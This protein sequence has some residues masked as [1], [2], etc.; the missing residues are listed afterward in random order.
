MSR[1]YKHY[2]LRPASRPIYT[3]HYRSLVSTVS[4]YKDGA[5]YYCYAAFSS[6]LMEKVGTKLPEGV[7]PRRPAFLHVIVEKDRYEVYARYFHDGFTIH[8]WSGVSDNLPAWLTR[9]H[10]AKAVS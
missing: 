9:L 6:K 8:L 7:S 10:K 5:D 3:Q 2:Q 1:E 4:V